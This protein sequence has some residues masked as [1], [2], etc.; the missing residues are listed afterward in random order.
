M[1][2]EIKESYV[3]CEDEGAK[4]LLLHCLL[5]KKTAKSSKKKGHSCRTLCFAASRLAAHRL[6][7]LLKALSDKS[8]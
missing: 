1:P 8:D 3:L 4:P 2:A 6:C 5:T 7:L